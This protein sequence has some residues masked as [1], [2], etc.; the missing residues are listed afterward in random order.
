M[1]P[2]HIAGNMWFLLEGESLTGSAGEEERTLHG[3]QIVRVYYFD[4]DGLMRVQG[5]RD[6]IEVE[7]T[8]FESA[9]KKLTGETPT[10]KT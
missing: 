2:E 3:E 5:A 7:G 1:S 4:E 8:D 10:E 6:S 9:V